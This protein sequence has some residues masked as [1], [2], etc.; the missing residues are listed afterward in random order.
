MQKKET[1]VKMYSTLT[2]AQHKK[3]TISSTTWWGFVK[4]QPC[5]QNNCLAL[6]MT[7]MGLISPH[8][9]FILSWQ[10][11]G[12]L[13]RVSYPLLSLSPHPKCLSLHRAI[14]SGL[15]HRDTLKFH[16][17]TLGCGWIPPVLRLLCIMWCFSPLSHPT[18]Y[19][20]IVEQ[21]KREVF[22]VQTEASNRNR[23]WRGGKRCALLSMILFITFKQN[24]Y[25]CLTWLNPDEV[26]ASECWRKSAESEN[27]LETWESEAL[28][29]RATGSALHQET[30][31]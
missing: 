11:N 9:S 5:G 3:E 28:I 17:A 14:L 4:R 18:Y 21:T 1:N 23:P 26:W 27:D 20:K 30:A 22:K 10:S 2:R 8:F 16:A 6:G 7:H 24:V 25:Y 12:C 29:K 13:W 19:I 15:V 31:K